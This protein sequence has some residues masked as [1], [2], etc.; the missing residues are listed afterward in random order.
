[1]HAYCDEEVSKAVFCLGCSEFLIAIKTP[2]F[3]WDFDACGG[4]VLHTHLLKSLC[5]EKYV[6]TLDQPI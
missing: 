5:G 1:M 3:R 6:V 4:G 2:P